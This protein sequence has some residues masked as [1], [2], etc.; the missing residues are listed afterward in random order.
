MSTKQ[1]G[2]R[3]T[4]FV[5]HVDK[6][7]TYNAL[8]PLS[9]LEFFLWLLGLKKDVS[10]VRFP[11]ARWWYQEELCLLKTLQPGRNL[12]GAAYA[13]YDISNEFPLSFSDPCL[14]SQ[15]VLVL[16]CDL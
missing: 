3:P 15:G 12:V 11:F 16:V 5:G 14:L 7:D 6:R 9:W 13:M 4:F 2:T 1:N 10:S 8:K